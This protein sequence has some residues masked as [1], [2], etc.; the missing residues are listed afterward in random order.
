VT[1]FDHYIPCREL[2][3]DDEIT[4]IRKLQKVF[5]FKITSEYA[6][7]ID[8]TDPNDPLRKQVVP[9][10]DELNVSVEESCDPLDEKRYMPLPGL[11]HKYTGRVLWLVTASCPLHCRFCFRRWKA[12]DTNDACISETGIDQV[13]EYLERNPSVLEIILSGGDPFMM[14]RNW[15]NDCLRTLDTCSSLRLVR[16]HTRMPVA[17]GENGYEANSL[18]KGHNFTTR[19]VLHVNHLNEISSGLK[20][21]VRKMQVEGTAVLTQTV[22][23]AGVNDSKQTLYDLFLGLVKIGVQPYYLHYPDYA[24]GTGHFRMPVDEAIKLHHFLT[25]NLPGYAVPKLVRD[26]PGRAAKTIL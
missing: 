2:L 3:L 1:H 14:D 5:P 16:F 26:I 25:N 24:E 23:L 9:S 19:I 8:W 11:I 22:L 17:A 4:A 18:Y 10:L 21:F 7:L 13:K 15:L 20:R 12:G 6:A